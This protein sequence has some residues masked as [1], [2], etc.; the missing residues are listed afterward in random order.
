MYDKLN[1]SDILTFIDVVR[2]KKSLNTC[3]K[4]LEV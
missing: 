3:L 1:F 4:N 2:I